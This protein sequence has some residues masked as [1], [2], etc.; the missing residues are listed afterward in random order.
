VFA[1]PRYAGR[2]RMNG[3]EVAN[4]KFVPLKQVRRLSSPNHTCMLQGLKL[5]CRIWYPLCSMSMHKHALKLRLAGGL[6]CACSSSWDS[7][8]QC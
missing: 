6:A 5:E 8:L 7:V 2:V 4:V 1:L 3:S